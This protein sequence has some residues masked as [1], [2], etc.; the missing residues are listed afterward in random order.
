MNN[1]IQLLYIGVGG[2]CGAISRWLV[3]K[4]TSNWLGAFPLG[5]LLVNTSGS[6]ILGFIMYSV[7]YGKNI[8]PESRNFIAV[9]FIGAFTTMSTFSYETVR[10]LELKD[11][12]LFSI[13]FLSNI[14]LCLAAIVVGRY[15]AMAL[16]E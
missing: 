4:S 10:L 8:S 16:F 7:A 9:G 11:Y 2:F 15:L 5:T 13:N 3:S 1:F 12:T 6:L 14:I